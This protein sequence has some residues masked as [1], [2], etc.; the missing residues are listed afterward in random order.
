[1]LPANLLQEINGNTVAGGWRGECLQRRK[2]GSDLPVLLSTGRLTD[3]EGRFAGVFAAS[4][5]G[6][7]V[8]HSEK[9]LPGKKEL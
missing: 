4:I 6:C 5:D 9:M 7:F 8:G 2:D 3:R 1:M